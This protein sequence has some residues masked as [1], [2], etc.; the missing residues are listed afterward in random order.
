MRSRGVMYIAI[1]ALGFSAMSVMVKVASN[2]L[3]TGEIVLARG[4]GT[5]LLSFALVRRAGLSP[6]GNE[7]AK[8]ALRGFLGFSA[9]AC[10]YGALA[11][12][13]LADATV[14]QNTIPVITALLAWWL[15]GERVGWGAAVAIACGLGGVMLVMNPSGDPGDP[16]GVALALGGACLSAT[17]YVTVRQ[18]SKTE[19]SLV[20]VLYFPLIATPLAI[21]WAVSVWV[22]PSAQEWLLL[23]AIGVA[24]QVGQVFL[25]MGLAA[26]KAARATAAGYLQICFA[27]GWQLLVFG[28][29]PNVATLAG[30][31]LIIAGTLAVEATRR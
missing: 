18:L 20:I 26:E 14:L 28:N 24:T 21:P 4:V 29:E 17:A 13:P 5:L 10:Y 12:L 3:P 9:L 31:A 15:L 16:I 8:L 23:A 19:H 2:T 22:W 6:W 30:A 11:R 27:I 7:R 1:S 25:T